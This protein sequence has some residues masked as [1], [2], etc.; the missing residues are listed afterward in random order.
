MKK[1]FL[2][3]HALGTLA[4]SVGCAWPLLLAM[5]IAA[6]AALCVCCCAG[7]T[8]LFALGDCVPRLRAACYPLLLV[9]IAAVVFPYRTQLQAVSAALTLFL[10]G[11]SVALT[12]YARPVCALVSL[13]MGGVAAS[14]A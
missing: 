8:L 13:L 5:D 6:P 11:Q 4:I 3:L 1:R 10:H 14:L 9:S 12:A 2:A 7:V